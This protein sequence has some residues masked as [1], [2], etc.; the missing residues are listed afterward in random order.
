M[1]S[2]PPP[3][4]PG[5][6]PEYPIR[7]PKAEAKADKAYAKAMRPWYK[8]KRYMI[9]LAV[10]ALFAIIGALGGG[11]DDNTTAQPSGSGSAT[12]SATNETEPK[13]TPSPEGE[14]KA[15]P[16]EESSPE[17]EPKPKAMGVKAGKI[18]KE[19]EENEARADAKY[20][21]K[22][23]RV[24]GEVAKVDTEF[25]DEDQYVIQVGTGEDFEFS[26]VNCN[27]ISSAV[28]QKVSKGDKVAVVGEFDD[29]GDLGVELKDCELL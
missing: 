18:L 25:L 17:P 2:I 15:T 19:F 11:G 8:K 29:G 28:A 26:F 23:L 5:G 13:S 1:S 21:D 14:D 24:T 6:Q 3:G 20:K 12:S 16:T 4:P 7:N 9:P 27:D 22:T 10:V